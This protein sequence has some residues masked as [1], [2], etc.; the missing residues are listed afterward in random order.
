MEDAAKRGAIGILRPPARGAVRGA[1]VIQD[2][3]RVP[4]QL[5][6]AN[7]RAVRRV[8][9][10]VPPRRAGVS[11]A[12][13]Y[14]Q[15]RRLLYGGAEDHSMLLTL[16]TTHAPATDLGYLLHKRPDRVQSFPLSFGQAHVFY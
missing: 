6:A 15:A 4:P 3:A 1:S 8:L 5:A 14:E 7:V 13:Q 11:P 16:T 9:Q 12:H 10:T 2:A